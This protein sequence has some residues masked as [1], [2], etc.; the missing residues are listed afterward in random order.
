VAVQRRSSDDSERQRSG[1]SLTLKRERLLSHKDIRTGWRGIS[2]RGA[3]K[4]AA[5]PPSRCRQRRH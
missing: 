3:T 4:P 5:A 1:S 2:F